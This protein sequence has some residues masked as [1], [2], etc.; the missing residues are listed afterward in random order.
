MAVGGPFA[1]ASVNLDAH[2][3]TFLVGA[4]TSNLNT[5]APASCT[6]SFGGN[7]GCSGLFF[8]GGTLLQLDHGAAGPARAR[9]IVSSGRRWLGSPGIVVQ[10]GVRGKPGFPNW[11]SALQSGG[12]RDGECARQLCGQQ[13]LRTTDRLRPRP[14]RRCWPSRHFVRWRWSARV[15]AHET[16]GSRSL[17]DRPRSD[18]R[19]TA[20]RRSFCS[21]GLFHGIPASLIGRLGSSTFRLS[22]AA[23]SMS[24][25]G[26]RFSSKSAPRPFHHGIRGR[27]GTIYW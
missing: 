13:Y 6:S 11:F 7:A 3:N 8:L 23:V 12:W 26:S 22:T 15:V 21:R 18:F 1:S 5:T 24:L 20:L 25:T 14:H 10:R 27:G 9:S 17:I 2:I 4:L 16:E 19:E